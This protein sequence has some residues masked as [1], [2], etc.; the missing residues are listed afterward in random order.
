MHM[1][2][3]TATGGGLASRVKMH[4]VSS[5]NLYLDRAWME[6]YVLDFF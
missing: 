1:F 5:K 6:W 3:L 4:L 2:V